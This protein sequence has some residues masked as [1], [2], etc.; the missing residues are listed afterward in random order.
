[1]K[2]KA[3]PALVTFLLLMSFYAYSDS[4]KVTVDTNIRKQPTK[5]ASV[6]AVASAGDKVDL[7][8]S[9]PTRGYYHVRTT[10]GDEGWLLSK[11][12]STDAVS[13]DTSSAPSGSG[14]I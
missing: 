5:S 3:I 9:K 8:N 12:V 11:N 4:A 1:M 10:S 7:L 2:N 13:S 6:V 14:D